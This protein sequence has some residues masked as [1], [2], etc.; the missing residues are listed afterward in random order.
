VEIVLRSGREATGAGRMARL[1]PLDANELDRA[2]KM[3]LDTGEAGS[4]E[5]AQRIFAGYRLQVLVGHDAA[6]SEAWQMALLT[7]VNAGVRAFKGGV[8]VQ[9]P[10]GDYAGDAPWAGGRSLGD[11]VLHFGGELV[12]ELD[13]N[14][15]TLVLGESANAPDAE[16]ILW[17]RAGGWVGYVTPERDVDAVPEPPNVLAAIL[18]AALG[19]A[20][21]FQHVRG[22]IVAA[23]RTI[24]LSLWRPDLDWRHK[25]AIGPQLSLMPA[26]WWLIGLGH[27]GQA[28][29][30]V[31]GSLPYRDPSGVKLMLQD[32]DILV[33]ANTASSLLA[34]ESDADQYKTRRVANAL[35][36][37]GFKTGIVERRLD[38]AQRLGRG[39]PRIGLIGVDNPASRRQLEK[40]GFDLVVDAGLGG[41]PRDY[42]DITMH[43]FPA[44]Q[45]PE[46]V[47]PGLGEDRGETLVDGVRA[48]QEQERSGADRCGLIEVAGRAVATAFVGVTAA[49][50]VVAEAI[51]PALGGMSS[52]ILDLSLRVPQYRECLGLDTEREM[53][54]RFATARD[55]PEGSP[56]AAGTRRVP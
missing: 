19:V 47:F 18:A 37:L 41:G 54:W 9:L 51:R 20:E 29:S 6:I 36:D 53:R 3:A 27:L 4:A 46:A 42:L 16:L 35:E 31:I 28:Y 33:R 21:C 30:W 52:E 44:P 45:D 14:I 15:P 40:P 17:V 11:A 26:E 55:Y 34:T 22:D 56:P 49:C 12:T 32:T 38:E 8:A 1:I 10:R 50:F 5:E 23:N 7:V 39:E 25:E 48:Y 24:G 13:A 2:V 43:T